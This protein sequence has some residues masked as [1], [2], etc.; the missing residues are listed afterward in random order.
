M[1]RLGW[2]LMVGLGKAPMVGLGSGRVRLGVVGVE[3]GQEIKGNM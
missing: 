2:N 1:A 3:S